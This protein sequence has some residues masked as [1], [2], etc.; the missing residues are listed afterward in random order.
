MFITPEDHSH[1][2]MAINIIVDGTS[3]ESFPTQLY[4]YQLRANTEGF[5]YFL[6]LFVTVHI[7]AAI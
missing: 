5:S 3:L 6:L 7:A 4:M 1:I 2:R